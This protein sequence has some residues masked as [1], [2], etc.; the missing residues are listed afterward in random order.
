MQ[1]ESHQVKDHLQ[2]HQYFTINNHL[3]FEWLE[4]RQPEISQKSPFVSAGPHGHV[5]APAH[6]RQRRL[7]LGRSYVMPPPAKMNHKSDS[8]GANSFVTPAFLYGCFTLRE[9][10]RPHLSLSENHFGQ[11][12]SSIYAINYNR[13]VKD[14]IVWRA[15]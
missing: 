10:I 7:F 8:C 1:S 15:S 14:L 6:T 9:A 5:K 3:T 4:I 12:F 2:T 13:P 11:H